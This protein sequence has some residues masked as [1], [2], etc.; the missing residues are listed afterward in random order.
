M[1]ETKT[2][3]LLFYRSI[4]N[5]RPESQQEALEKVAQIKKEE[6]NVEDPSESLKATVLRLYFIVANIINRLIWIELDISNSTNDIK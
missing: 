3:L 2:S 4:I 1:L 5:E 6:A